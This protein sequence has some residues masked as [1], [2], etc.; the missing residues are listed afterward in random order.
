MYS[1]LEKG[2]AEEEMMEITVGLKKQDGLDEDHSC[3]EDIPLLGD[4]PIETSD[5]NMPGDVP[6]ETSYKNVHEKTMIVKESEDNTLTGKM[7][8]TENSKRKRLKTKRKRASIN[9]QVSCLL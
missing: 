4:L 9:S 2:H 7:T 5:K 1:Y 8:A 6:M 3:S